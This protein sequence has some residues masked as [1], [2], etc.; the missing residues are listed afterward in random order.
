MN[1]AKNRKHKFGDTVKMRNQ[2][3]REQATKQ[4]SRTRTRGIRKMRNDMRKKVTF[5]QRPGDMG[6]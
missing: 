4:T 3:W 1:K 6:M 2:L 5:E